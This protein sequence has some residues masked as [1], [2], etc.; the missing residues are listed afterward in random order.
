MS[1]LSLGQSRALVAYAK[2][3]KIQP[4]PLLL[5]GK[6]A[7]MGNFMDLNNGPCKCIENIRRQA[8]KYML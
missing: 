6:A 5:S 7:G 3:H 4:A 1:V 2:K 8:K